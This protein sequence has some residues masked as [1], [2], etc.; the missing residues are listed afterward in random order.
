MSNAVGKTCLL[1]NPIKP[2]E[3]VVYC[4][5]CSISPPAM[6]ERGR[7]VLLWLSGQ[8]TGASA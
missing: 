4:S 5:A 1:P 6:L 3:E 7:V 8:V 2:G